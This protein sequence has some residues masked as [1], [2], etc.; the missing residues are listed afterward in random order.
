MVTKHA[1]KS[2]SFIKMPRQREESHYR[3]ANPSMMSK[4]SSCRISK[5]WL[6]NIRRKRI[7]WMTLRVSKKRSY[8]KK[9][10]VY[11][12][13]ISKNCSTRLSTGTLTII[14]DPIY[15]HSQHSWTME[16]ES[17]PSKQALMVAC[18]HPLPLRWFKIWFLTLLILL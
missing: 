7:N 5:T 9:Q 14:N 13:K 16:H 4:S 6:M 2:K 18:K 3:R 15:S 8:I 17:K 1:S 12:R 11:F 10:F